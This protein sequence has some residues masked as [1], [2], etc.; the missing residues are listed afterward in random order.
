MLLWAIRCIPF[1]PPHH[2]LGEVQQDACIGMGPHP[3]V[4]YKLPRPKVGEKLFNLCSRIT[5]NVIEGLLP[6]SP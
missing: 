5:M 3:N 1:L 4:T 6:D 2:E